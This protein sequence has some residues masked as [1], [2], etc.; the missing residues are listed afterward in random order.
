M[1]ISYHGV[2]GNYALDEPLS[3]WS[4]RFR[5]RKTVPRGTESDGA[6]WAPDIL[7][8][9]WWIHD[10]LCKDGT[11]DDGT[12]VTAYQ[13]A[14]VLGDILW[15]EK[16][17]LRSVLWGLLTFLFGCLKCRENGWLWIKK[18]KRKG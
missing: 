13:A 6:T 12:P 8:L 9:S 7:S 2:N 5:K 14:R 3:Y 1:K 17:W 15:T 18:S 11:W 4:P 16:Q 10:E